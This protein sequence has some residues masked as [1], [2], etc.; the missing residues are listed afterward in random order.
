MNKY[1]NK[2]FLYPIETLYCLFLES[3]LEVKLGK[4]KHDRFR[5]YNEYNE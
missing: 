4:Q 2:M 3:Y 5:K 1:V